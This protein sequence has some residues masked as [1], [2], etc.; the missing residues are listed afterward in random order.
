MFATHPAMAKRWA[1]ETP[2][3]KGLPKKVNKKKPLLRKKKQMQIDPNQVD[4]ELQQLLSQQ[5]YGFTMCK[6]D[7]IQQVKNVT[8]VIVRDYAPNVIPP[9]T[10]W[11]WVDIT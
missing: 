7:A 11:I 10:G 3:I 2:N 9:Q 8:A 6:L 4:S 5:V 1:D